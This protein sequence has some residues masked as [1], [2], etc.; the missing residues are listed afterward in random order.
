MTA[1]ESLAKS[2]GNIPRNTRRFVYGSAGWPRR[3]GGTGRGGQGSQRV[4][5][6]PPGC[7]PGGLRLVPRLPPALALAV[8]LHP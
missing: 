8:S 7:H 4:E 1:Q 2:S 5:S 3:P 6:T